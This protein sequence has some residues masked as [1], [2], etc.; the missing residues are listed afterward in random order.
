MNS[1]NIK[2]LAIAITL[3]FSMGA[4]AQNTTKAEYKAGNDKISAEVKAAKAGCASLSGNANDIC[5]VEAK[6]IEKVARAEL[7]ASYKPT[8]KNFY[9][10]RIAK[11]E[12]DY[13]V[14]KEKCDELSGN[15]KD[16]CVKEAK[17]LQTTA[18][19]EAKAQLKT[20][21]ANATANETSAKAQSKAN[22]KSTQARKDAT[23]DEIDASYAVA[24]E[25]CDTFAGEAKEICMDKAKRRFGK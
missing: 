22:D 2:A 4:M 17:A 18:K 14:A 23:G 25:K 5:V 12:A 19:A 21:D 13:G 20:T 11:A 6:G 10:V 15:T 8:T 9:E 24:K 7:E 16:V 3:T 1:F